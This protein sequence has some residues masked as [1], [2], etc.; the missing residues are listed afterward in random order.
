MLDDYEENWSILSDETMRNILSPAEMNAVVSSIEG[1]LSMTDEEREARR[2]R[3]ERLVRRLLFVLQLYLIVYLSNKLL[4][5][6]YMGCYRSA[7]DFFMMILTYGVA[8]DVYGFCLAYL[9]GA[10]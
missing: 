8:I 2:L 7:F 4:M 1:E 10:V 3:G 9:L 6:T 5:T